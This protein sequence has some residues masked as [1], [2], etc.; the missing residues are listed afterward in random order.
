M[1]R[2]A[3]PS[4]IPNST[5]PISRT[6]R[7]MSG[8]PTSSST[9][10]RHSQ[11]QLLREDAVLPKR[12]SKMRVSTSSTELSDP[13]QGRFSPKSGHS[14][15]RSSPE[16]DVL[17]VGDR[18]AV[19]SLHIEGTLRFL[20]E[21]EFKPGRWAGIELD[22]IGSG[23]NDGS[24]QGVR[25]FACPPSSGLFIQETKV[26]KITPP[27]AVTQVQPAPTRTKSTAS[28]KRSKTLPKMK[29]SKTTVTTTTKR[30]SKRPSRFSVDRR[31]T[32][33][34]P[35]LPPPA[36]IT[37]THSNTIASPSL[38]PTATDT[39][40]IATAPTPAPGAPQPQQQQ[41]QQRSTK[42][43]SPDAVPAPAPGSP[44]SPVVT[45]A[46][47]TAA[48]EEQHAQTVEELHRMYDLLEKAQRE[49][50]ELGAQMAQKEAAW[51]RL[52]S[53]KESYALRVQEKEEALARLQRQ[54]DETQTAYDD[55]RTRA[56]VQ[57]E[58]TVRDD[59]THEVA[60]RKITKLEQQIQDLKLQ[61]QSQASTH[62]ETHT[63]LEGELQQLKHALADRETMVST[64][65]RECEALRQAELDAMYA[66]KNSL[67][68]IQQD[69]EQAMLAKQQELDQLQLVA[70]DLKR[71]NH[72]L[73]GYEDGEEEE[74]PDYQQ[75]LQQQ[76]LRR[77]LEEQLELATLELEREREHGQSLAKEIESLRAEMKHIHANHASSDDR[78]TTLRAELEQEVADKRRLMEEAD[79]AFEAQARAEDENYQLKMAKATLERELAELKQQQQQEQ[80]QKA[81]STKPGDP[82]TPR[83]EIDRLHEQLALERRRYT[84][85]EVSKAAEINLLNKDL[86]ELEGLVES[87]VFGE[88]DLEEALEAEKQ[89][90]KRLEAKL[91]QQQQ[92]QLPQSNQQDGGGSGGA[93]S[94]SSLPFCELCETEG[95]DIVECDA[96]QTQVYC[97][98][99][100]EY[101]KHTTR[102][103]PSQD[104]VF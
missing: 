71:R 84:E 9:V 1:S 97:E 79:A 4:T 87:R 89:K 99:C 49:R 58:Q 62:A 38:T 54:M 55:L 104:E 65:E 24:V 92:H 7:L 16:A 29:P 88:N 70:D 100:E 81:P 63:R 6:A 33:P 61:A 94:S 34:P 98:N 11:P 2:I 95:H 21:T 10:K 103:C 8:A 40:T 28:A 14:T 102:D 52:V 31:S 85:L 59:Q 23:K 17:R 42:T 39:T 73:L 20:G 19:P 37:N 46:A 5:L 3:R 91:E 53:A 66:Y 43:P 96:V 60:Q 12:R 51:E 44:S 101:G 35:P 47:A 69:H 26:I 50:D 32:S 68:Q 27:P 82:H 75:Q 13:E 45:P 72:R 74:E 86:A 25:Y 67:N 36:A 15:P 93:V 90:V 77:R 57:A 56:D 64:L 78:F 22:A 80:E 83:S 18:V 76:Q 48:I 41:Q 30:P